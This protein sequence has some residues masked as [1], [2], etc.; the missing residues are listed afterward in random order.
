MSPDVP[1]CPGPE[2][3]GELKERMVGE[4]TDEGVAGGTE[5]GGTKRTLCDR[6]ENGVSDT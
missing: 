5:T 2:G 6:R 1:G 4:R 3:N